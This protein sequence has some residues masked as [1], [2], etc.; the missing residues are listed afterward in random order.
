MEDKI[1]RYVEGVFAG[2]PSNNKTE[3]I[4]EEIIQNIL[5]K[6]HD[7]IQEG[8]SKEDA[9]AIAISSAGDLSQIVE[10]LKASEKNNKTYSKERKKCST[11]ESVLWPITLCVYLIYSFL[12]HSW[13]YSWLIFLLS[14]VIA[15]VFKFFTVKN[16]IRVR[17]GALNSIVWVGTTVLY[18]IFSF[19][20]YRWDMTWILFVLAIPVNRILSLLIFKEEDKEKEG[21]L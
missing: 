12:T 15:S 6:Y 16:N 13:Y 1:K 17:K 9:Y 20:T 18:F 3:S 2:V 5:D 4:I 7:L 10:D 11:F 21:S 19:T 14:C 8:K